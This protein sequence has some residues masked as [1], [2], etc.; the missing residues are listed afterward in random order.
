[1][2]TKVYVVHHTNQGTPESGEIYGIY[3]TEEL[4]IQAMAACLEDFY[5]SSLSENEEEDY[6]YMYISEQVFH[7]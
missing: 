4:A 3:A 5:E 2:K 7:S 1:M 6:M